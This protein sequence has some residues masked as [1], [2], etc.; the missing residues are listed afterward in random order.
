MKYNFDGHNWL[1]QLNRGE[2][3]IEC[4][5][6]L[7]RQQNIHGTWISGLGAAAWVELGF[8]HLGKKEYKWKKNNE[9]LEI[10]NLQGNVAWQGESPVIH[11]HGCFSNAKG[12]AIGGHVKEL[13]VAGTCELF[14]TKFNQP[15]SRS[16]DADTGLNLLNLKG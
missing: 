15:I 3:L 9:L 13:E 11:L 2:K 16:A 8:Y 1:V 6:E 12:Q 4:L 14:L 7:A 10:L 5:T